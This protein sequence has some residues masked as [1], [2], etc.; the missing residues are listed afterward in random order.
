MQLNRS[1]GSIRLL[2]RSL[3]GTLGIRGYQDIVRRKVLTNGGEDC[4]LQSELGVHPGRLGERQRRAF[5]SSR[6]AEANRTYKPMI[7][8][9]SQGEAADVAEFPRLTEEDR[10]RFD[11]HTTIQAIKIP[12]Q[13]S[14]RC[15]KA[16]QRLLYKSSGVKRIEHCDDESKRLVLLQEGVTADLVD[17]HGDEGP[18]GTQPEV[19]GD[20]GKACTLAEFVTKNG[21]EVVPFVVTKGYGRMSMQ[22]VLKHFLPE[23]VEIPS[24][25]EAV[26]HIAHL[27]LKEGVL[28]YKYIIGQVILDKNPSIKTVVNKVGTITSEYRV[29]EMEVLAGEDVTETI[30]KQHGLRFKLDFRHVYWN[31]RLENEHGRLIETWIKA[32]DVVVDAMCGIGP[33]AVPAAKKGCRVFANDLNPESYRWLVENCRLNKVQDKVQCYNEDA[34]AFLR[35]AAGGGLY[36]VE[37]RGPA[38]DGQNNESKGSGTVA[39]KPPAPVAFDHIIMNLPASAVEFLDALKGEFSG[40]LWKDRE[41]PMVHVYSFLQ[42]TE[43]YDDMRQKIEKYLGGELDEAPEFFLVRD[44]APKK[45]MICSSFRVPRRIALGQDEPSRDE[46]RPK[47]G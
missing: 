35:R 30:V 13:E 39:D 12:K 23:D 40:Q 14:G 34:R 36:V 16:L 1:V 42:D 20:D 31:S 5:L 4:G 28:K 27:N 11:V 43:T 25:F 33:F 2:S 47:I 3:R 41:L 7:A 32:S 10:R 6:P 24:S 44:V 18:R 19:M 22:E 29:F 26:G 8:M 9:A 15:M 46:K 38:G 21:Y 45:A 17:V 37:S